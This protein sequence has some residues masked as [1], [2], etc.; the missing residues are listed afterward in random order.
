MLLPP[1]PPPDCFQKTD[2]E[3]GAIFIITFLFMQ[4]CSIPNPIVSGKMHIKG[5]L[6]A[7]MQ[8]VMVSIFYNIVYIYI[9]QE[10]TV[11]RS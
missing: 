2:L 7:S 5:R 6:L 8:F 4:E 9:H 11:Y 1:P 3:E 10:Y